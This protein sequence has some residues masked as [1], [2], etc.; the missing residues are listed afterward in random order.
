MSKSTRILNLYQIFVHHIN[1]L[2]G[3]CVSQALKLIQS[4]AQKKPNE[5][6]HEFT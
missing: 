5:L 3:G 2:R 6:P 1:H 4:K